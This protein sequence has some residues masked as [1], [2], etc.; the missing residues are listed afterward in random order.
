MINRTQGV[1]CKTKS[2]QSIG[3]I[4]LSPPK[5]SPLDPE[6]KYLRHFSMESNEVLNVYRGTILFDANGE[7]VVEL[8]SYFNDINKNVSYQLTPVGAYMPL[9]VKEKVNEDNK[10][11]VAGGIA[12]KEVSWAIHAERNDLY[13]QK[14]P[15]HRDTELE[16]RPQEKGKYLIPSLYNAGEDKAIFGNQPT[17]MAQKP[18]NIMK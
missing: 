11:V 2:N 5:A 10:F 16:K 6:N 15:H 14:N 18:L 8:P 13:L 3:R 1:A 17:K 7:A 12:G 4:G 9:Y